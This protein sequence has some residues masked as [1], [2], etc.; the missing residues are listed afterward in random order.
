MQFAPGTIWEY[1]NT[2]YTVLGFVIEKITGRP[3]TDY[4]YEHIFKPAGW[5]IPVLMKICP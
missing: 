4:I 1:N 5:S 2:N 3:Y